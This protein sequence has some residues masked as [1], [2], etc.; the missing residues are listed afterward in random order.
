LPCLV[1]A[2]LTRRRRREREEAKDKNGDGN[3]NG[4]N[5][6]GKTSPSSSPLPLPLFSEIFATDIDECLPGLEANAVKN[7]PA[8]TKVEVVQWEDDEAKEGEG[9]GKTRTAE[10]SHQQ[11]LKLLDLDW[12]LFPRAATGFL[13]PP[14]DVVLVAD[15]VYIPGLMPALVEAMRSV[16]DEQSFVFLSYYL[17]SESADL[18]FW[19]RLRAAFEVDAIPA[20]SFGCEGA[21][22][23]ENRGLFRLRKRGQKEFEEAEEKRRKEKEEEKEEEE[24]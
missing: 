11:S 5:N 12:R 16:S 14:F 4:N 7:A 23:G 13:Q 21:D 6:D 2:R 10:T 18:N 1:A 8:T 3:S 9:E 24:E 20:A 22:K 19:P 17:R 15:A